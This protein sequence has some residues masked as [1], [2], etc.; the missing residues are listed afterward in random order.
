MHGPVAHINSSKAKVNL[1]GGRGGGEGR[2]D[3]RLFTWS[4][5]TIRLSFGENHPGIWDCFGRELALGVGPFLSKESLSM[6]LNEW[7]DVF[8]MSIMSLL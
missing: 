8:P 1:V 4:A 6:I 2:K 7:L 3:Q 5:V